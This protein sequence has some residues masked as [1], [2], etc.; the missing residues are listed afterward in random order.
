MDM[1]MPFWWSLEMRVKVCCAWHTNECPA[2]V[3]RAD[4][5]WVVAVCF[6]AAETGCVMKEH[7]GLFVCLYIHLARHH[8]LIV[9]F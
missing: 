9:D 5:R 7:G 4:S 2:G 8:M 6:P 3:T 1:V